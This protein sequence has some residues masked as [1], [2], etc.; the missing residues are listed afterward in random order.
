MRIRNRQ[1][2]GKVIGKVTV[3]QNADTE[4]KR[5]HQIQLLITNRSPNVP[6]LA[7]C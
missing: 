2:F 3:T 7:F 6:D 4:R 1:R 5:N